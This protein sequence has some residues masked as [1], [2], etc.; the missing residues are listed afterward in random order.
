MYKRDLVTAEIEKLAQ[1]LAK[2]IGLKLEDRL[3]EADSLFAET[4][5]SGFGLNIEMLQDINT[6]EFETWLSSNELNAE[7]LNLL[8]DF[9]FSEIDFE[10]RPVISGIYASKL[11]LVYKRLT[12]KFQ[13]VHLINMGRQKYIEQYL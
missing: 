8:S 4:I 3:V 12:D 11:I 13:M 10:G 7:Q 9:I 1:V 5:K 2:I 6:E